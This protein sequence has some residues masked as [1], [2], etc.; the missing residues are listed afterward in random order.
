MT[1]I[2]PQVLRKFSIPYDKVLYSHYQF[3][4]FTQLPE[5]KNQATNFIWAYAQ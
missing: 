1:I 5:N 3:T 2:S 4:T